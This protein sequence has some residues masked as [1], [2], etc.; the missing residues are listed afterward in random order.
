MYVYQGEEVGLWE[1]EDIPDERRR[2]PIWHRTGGA[3]P[4]RDGSRV[5]LP[6]TGQE[7]PFG[8]SPADATAQPWL[9]APDRVLAFDRGGLACVAN[10]SSSPVKLP[11][12][13][14]ILL[15]SGP[16]PGGL[17]PPDIAAWLRIPSR[18]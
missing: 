11:R 16:L 14:A 12:H 10:L 8:F 17:L 9:P 15:A 13:T 1:V 4:G 2:D 18:P 3:D 6:W 7:P 5:P